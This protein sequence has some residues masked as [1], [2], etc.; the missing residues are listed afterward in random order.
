[1]CTYIYAHIYTYIHIYTHINVPLF[2]GICGLP[3]DCCKCGPLLPVGMAT[4]SV[5]GCVVALKEIR[6]NSE[7][8]TPFTAIREGEHLLEQAQDYSHMRDSPPP[9]LTLPISPIAS[10]LKE[11][12]HSNI[13]TLHDIIHVPG[14]LTFVFEYVVSEVTCMSHDVSQGCH[15]TRCHLHTANRPVPLHG[16]APWS[17]QSKQC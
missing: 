14:N 3:F 9:S 5:M 7:E 1:M 4:C 10:L 11:L 15:L 16:E 13:V 12:K 6:L 2:V 8:G 17:T